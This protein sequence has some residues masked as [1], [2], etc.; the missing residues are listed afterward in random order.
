MKTVMSIINNQ[1]T[2]YLVIKIT[3]IAASI[4]FIIWSAKRTERLNSAWWHTSVRATI[5]R[6]VKKRKINISHTNGSMTNEMSFKCLRSEIK[7]KYL[8]NKNSV[9]M[10]VDFL[11]GRSF[12][13]LCQHWKSIDWVSQEKGINKHLAIYVS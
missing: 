6:I 3:T 10:P 5:K 1:M 2:Q 4:S 8:V 12:I 11:D 7:W 9:Y 13:T